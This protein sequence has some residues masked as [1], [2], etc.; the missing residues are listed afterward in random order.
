MMFRTVQPR[1]TPAL[2]FW[3]MPSRRAS[4]RAGGCSLG[5]FEPGA[6]QTA[7][8]FDGVCGLATCDFA[9]WL[10]G[11]ALA[12][13]L[14]QNGKNFCR[15]VAC[16]T[17]G[18][19]STASCSPHHRP[20]PWWPWLSVLFAPSPRVP[21]LQQASCTARRNGT[22]HINAILVH[23]QN[24][25]KRLLTLITRVFVEY[26]QLRHVASNGTAIRR[27]VGTSIRL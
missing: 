25:S 4:C 7:P 21:I 15:D 11:G 1:E 2:V 6:H 14:G 27:R 20:S 9:G 19:L 13:R 26:A 10:G 5:S 12:T 23:Q 18:D 3:E 24:T 22:L 16:Y 8:G 17:R